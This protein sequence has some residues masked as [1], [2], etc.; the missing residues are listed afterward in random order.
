MEKVKSLGKIFL[1][2]YVFL[3]VYYL[4]KFTY[5]SKNK[6]SC[7]DAILVLGG[8]RPLNIDLPPKWVQE[9]ANKAATVF[10]NQASCLK[11]PYILSLSG[12]SAHLPQLID[13]ETG[14]PVFESAS[15]ANYLYKH[16]NIPSK[17]LM[18]ETSSYDTL[19]NAYFARTSYV[20]VQDWKKLLIIT[21][22]SHM[23]RTKLI[24]DWIFSLER[25]TSKTEEYSLHYLET[26]DNGLESSVLIA[27]VAKEEKSIKNLKKLKKI[28]NLKKLA[29]F[30]LW[31]TKEHD[32]YS[33]GRTK[34][35]NYNISEALRK[36]YG[37]IP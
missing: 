15:T 27:R 19:G 24:F 8:G 3:L 25:K 11:K 14:L 13:N 28:L 22:K 7:Y 12:G 1:F 9:R 29:D 21:S 31:L 10:M 32:L 6:E 34:R 30:Q 37:L 16:F 5:T 35:N 23:K 17:Y 18:F 26:F 36:S 20:D 4:H 2:V 33:I